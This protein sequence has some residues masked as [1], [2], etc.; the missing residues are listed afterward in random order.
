MVQKPSKKFK[1]K[2]K[3]NIELKIKPETKE[4]ATEDTEVTIETTETAITMIAIKIRTTMM[5][6]EETVNLNTKRKI[7][8]E[9]AATETVAEKTEMLKKTTTVRTTT[10]KELTNLQSKKSFNLMTM[11]WV[12]CSRRTSKITQTRRKW[13][14]RVWLKKKRVKSKKSLPISRFTRK[15]K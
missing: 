12:K 14:K 5:A 3:I 2:S 1:K 9:E 6:V 15:S 8:E 11:K 7:P 10:P 4:M 13:L